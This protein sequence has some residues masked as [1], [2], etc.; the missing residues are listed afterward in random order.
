M[1]RTTYGSAAASSSSEKWYYME[2]GKKCGPVDASELVSMLTA[3]TLTPDTR[4]WTKGM[5]NWAPADATDLVNRVNGKKQG[6]V[7][8]NLKAPET[9]AKRRKRWWIW[10]IIGILL[11]IIV[12]VVCAVMVF[13]KKNAAPV[14]NE[15]VAT[16]P[17]L[18]YGLEDPV[19]F[20]NEECAFLID[21][22]G[23]KGDYLELDV[24]CV[25][26]TSDVLSF[27]WNSTSINGSMFDPLWE[28]YVQGNATM[29]SSITFPLS[30]LQSHNLLPGEEI[31]FILSVFNVD[32]FEKVREESEKY[33]ARDVS[34]TG[35]DHFGGCKVIEG[36]DGWFFSW[37]TQIDKKGRPYYVAKDKTN[38]YFDEIRDSDGNL[39]Y[40]PDTA[41]Y[42][43]GK[44]YDD[45]FG[46]P[47]YFSKTG[48]TVYYDGYGYAFYDKETSRYYY[49]DENGQIAY[50]GNNGVPECYEGTVSQELL[51]EGKPKKLESA[52]GHFIVHKEFS[53]YPTG[54]AAGEVTRPERISGD[55]EQV[56]WNGEKGSFI[57]LGGTEDVKGY[58]VHTYVENNTDNYFYFCWTDVTVNGL[59]A[60]PDSSIPLRPHSCSYRDILIPASILEELEIEAVEEIGF[61][62]DARGENLS[63]PLYPI[64]WEAPPVPENVE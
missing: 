9:P 29:K 61:T 20:E 58:T 27:S 24:C 38:V 42:W 3:G 19:I 25:N 43:T 8:T 5:A 60:Y 64:I 44:F 11:A 15:T 54:K 13:R 63:V 10:L 21:A 45:S 48:T 41:E 56:Y 26:K 23:E 17:V 34:S 57:L 22:I 49:Y 16:E 1:E 32:Q 40:K 6:P 30:N 12:G 37:R 28:V 46:R 2:S 50:Y 39:I 53:I 31:R 18:T 62:L 47:Y 4:V 59:P 7:A 14:S 52:D 36:Y 35:K 33:I 55:A 51:E